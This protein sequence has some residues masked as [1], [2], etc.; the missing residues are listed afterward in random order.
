MNAAPV[1]A[2]LGDIV[3]WLDVTPPSDPRAR[4]TIASE[5]L[6]WVVG[7]LARAAAESASV[8]TRER[9]EHLASVWS[10]HAA[11]R[12]WGWAP[13]PDGVTI[14]TS[15]VLGGTVRRSAVTAAGAPIAALIVVGE[16]KQRSN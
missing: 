15:A 1:T 11:V 6:T 14:G 9:G 12:G 2:A 10:E 7:C 3:D 4:F 16:P 8:A 13:A 5:H